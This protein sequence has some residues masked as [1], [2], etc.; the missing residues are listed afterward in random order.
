VLVPLIV[1]ALVC[2]A[3]TEREAS[4]QAIP[5]APTA[6][7][8]PVPNVSTDVQLVDIV[9]TDGRFGNDIYATQVG[10]SRLEI[11]THGGPFTF[12]IDPLVAPRELPANSTTTIGL[13]APDPTRYTMRLSG[14]GATSTATLNGRPIGGR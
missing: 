10:P 13:T 2:I 12:E 9:I 8:S 11:T 5:V 6:I 1:L 3:C 7:E 14:G 4:T